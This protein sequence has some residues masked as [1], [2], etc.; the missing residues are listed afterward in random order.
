MPFDFRFDLSTGVFMSP[1][2][3]KQLTHRA[4]QP[5]PVLDIFGAVIFRGQLNSLTIDDDA[6]RVLVYQRRWFDK[7]FF[8]SIYPHLRTAVPVEFG[9]QRFITWY[10]QAFEGTLLAE[11]SRM[12]EI[13]PVTVL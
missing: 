6:L 4:Q 12:P 8:P 13:D 1:N 9:R 7:K 2:L 3:T 11:N 5:G 10:H